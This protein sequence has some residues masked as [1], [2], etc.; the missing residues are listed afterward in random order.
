[1]RLGKKRVAGAGG[2]GLFVVLVVF[3][4]FA[5]ADIVVNFAASQINTAVAGQT[6]FTPTY[7]P[8][9]N[10]AMSSLLWP[11]LGI[12]VMFGSIIF[13]VSTSQRKKGGEDYS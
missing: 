5:I 4:I 9:I 12:M 7:I 2:Y 6:S 8:T 10:V 3:V 11:G 1:M 13:L